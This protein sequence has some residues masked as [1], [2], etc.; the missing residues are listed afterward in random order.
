MINTNIS[1]KIAKPITGQ[2]YIRRL[3][4]LANYKAVPFDYD[5]VGNNDEDVTTFRNLNIFYGANRFNFKVFRQS[6]ID[7]ILPNWTGFTNL[8]KRK[9]V[10]Q[11]VY[12][13]GTTDNEL[14]NILGSQQE[15]D[16]LRAKY[17][18]FELSDDREK[19]FTGYTATTDNKINY[20]SGNTITI[21]EFSN[22]TGNTNIN[23]DNKL[24]ISGGTINGSLDIT[25]DTYI[26]NRD[27]DGSYK[28]YNQITGTTDSIR[29]AEKVNG[30]FEDIFEIIDDFAT[31][32]KTQALK[33][34]AVPNG[35]INKF[36]QM[37]LDNLNDVGQLYTT[38]YQLSFW[39]DSFQRAKFNTFGNFEMLNNNYIITS[40]ITPSSDST[41]AIKITKSDGITSLLTF[42]TNNEKLIVPSGYTPIANEHL[43]NKEYVDDQLNNKTD[44]ITTGTTLNIPI[45]KSNGNLEDSGYA[46]SDLT[47]GTTSINWGDIIGTLSN[48]T[49]L[50][51][52]LN[53]KVDNNTFT[54]YT[55]STI[56]VTESRKFFV[57][58][59]SNQN[60][61]TSQNAITNWDDEAIYSDSD[62][63]SWDKLNGELTF[64]KNGIYEISFDLAIVDTNGN[65]RSQSRSYLQ[66]DTGSG[67]IN[68]PYTRKEHYNRQDDYGSSSSVNITR[69]FSTGDKIRTTAW[70][71]QGGDTLTVIGDST[72]LSVIKSEVG[73]NST[74][75]ITTGGTDLFIPKVTGATGNLGKFKSN[76]NLEDTGVKIEEITGSTGADN[77]F[78]AFSKTLSNGNQT[79]GFNLSVTRVSTGIYDYFFSSP[80]SNV[81]YGIFAQPYGTTT[82]TN[83][84]ISNVTTSGFRV[85]IGQGDNGSSPDVLVDT[86][87]SVGVFGVPISGFTGISVVSFNT[88]TGYTG[89]TDTRL[90]G[91]ENN[92]SVNSGNISNLQSNKLNVTDFNTYSGNTQNEINSKIP[93]ISGAAAD[94][95][96][97]TNVDGTIYDSGISIDNITGGTGFY[98]YV[99]KETTQTTSSNSNV[100]YLTGTGTGLQAG[101]WSVDFNAVGG[102]NQKNKTIF[103][104][105]YID[106]AL[107]GSEQTVESTS[108]SDRLSFSISKDLTL[109]AGSHTFEIR[110]RVGNG[111]GAI[112]YGAIR[113]KLV[114]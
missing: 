74:K 5:F 24:N 32:E 91:I 38:A 89:S 19:I 104:S 67:F 22:Y 40:Q 52:A 111:T 3:D 82:D 10:N 73:I 16:I 47:G 9:L 83:T 8:E 92:V 64:L 14:I 102:N 20:I 105:F 34:C 113:A 21:N 101:T 108:G 77:A 75:Y 97:L 95:I 61:L 57:G 42:D 68:I 44:K 28:I 1:F 15:L 107:Q 109:T 35:S 94:N 114:N 99:D 27:V 59:S 80:A 33:I 86:D 49:D 50:Q 55:A 30:N 98:F 60:L 106:N 36:I 11:N 69:E 7:S 84:Q 25:G 85:E 29:I 6:L 45:I 18:A 48:Q 23:L 51:N 58:K 110:F 96:A 56:G 12:P 37:K 88:F 66:E 54:G 31:N 46:I 71:T 78:Y 65:S 87:H 63:Y 4:I 70:K 72:S 79:E 76:G 17:S 103:V 43:I 93:K 81:N 41:D 39:S 90:Q 53:N 13:E 62:F 26:G 100:V 112:D 2:T